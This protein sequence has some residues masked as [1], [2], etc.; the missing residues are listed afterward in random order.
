VQGVP[1]GVAAVEKD[2]VRLVQGRYGH[3]AR[4]GKVGRYDKTTS[5]TEALP[6][7]PASRST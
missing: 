2:E 4:L 6:E 1:V 7:W 5:W 3:G